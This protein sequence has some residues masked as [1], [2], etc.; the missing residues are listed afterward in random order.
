VRF[1]RRCSL[2][3][4]DVIAL[5]R[6]RINASRQYGDVVGGSGVIAFTAPANR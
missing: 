2:L 5:I 3:D 4:Q 6:M 1:V